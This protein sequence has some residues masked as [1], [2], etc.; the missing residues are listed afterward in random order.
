MKRL[1]LFVL[2]YPILAFSQKK[3][4]AYF[5]ISPG[6]YKFEKN[7][8]VP[9]GT[10]SFGAHFKSVGVGIGASFTDVSSK[11]YVPIFIEVLA[12]PDKKI[13]PFFSARV[14][15]GIYNQKEKYGSITIT[16][17][18]GLYAGVNVGASFKS[19][20]ARF[21]IGAGYIRAEFKTDSK[22]F[23]STTVTD[24]MNGLNVFIGFVL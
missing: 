3:Q 10:F 22:S 13:A 20:K 21:V 14:G 7:D 8:A 4:K 9:Q 19:G 11:L 5:S 24:G 2:V 12:I 17:T 15:A 18:G 23:A 16:T 6:I 1:L